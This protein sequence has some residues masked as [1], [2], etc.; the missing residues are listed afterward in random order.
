MGYNMS[1]T[2]VFTEGFLCST[3]PS[4]EGVTQ[5]KIDVDLTN[6]IFGENKLPNQPGDATIGTIGGSP[7]VTITSNGRSVSGSYE[8]FY[9]GPVNY[10]V[11][12][13]WITQ[14]GDGQVAIPLVS[15]PFGS[16]NNRYLMLACKVYNKNYW[17]AAGV[18]RIDYEF[19]LGWSDS[20]YPMESGST[21]TRISSLAAGTFDSS[22]YQRSAFGYASFMHVPD[23]NALIATADNPLADICLVLGYATYAGTG[24]YTH[25]RTLSWSTNSTGVLTISNASIYSLFY[26]ASSY[27]WPTWTDFSEEVGEPSKEGGNKGGTF[28]NSSDAIAIP[29]NPTIGVS[30]V[31]FINVYRTSANGLQGLGA[32]LF[33][34]LSYTPP[35]ALDPNA[36]T[37]E[38]LIQ[39]FDAFVT[40]LANVPSFFDQFMAG[41][42]INYIIDC[43]VIP[44]DPGAGTNESIKVG[45]KTVNISAGRI[46]TDYVDFSCGSIA[47]GEYYTNFADYTGTS[48]KIYLPFVGFVPC[49]PEWFQ[50]ATL[51][52]DYKFNVIDGSFACYVRAGGSHVGAGSSTIVGQY[53]GNACIH[54]PITGVTY[55]NMVSGLVGSAGGMVSGAGS[56]NIA[57]VATSAINAASVHGDIAQSNSYNG[58]AAFLGCRYPF[59]LIERPVSSY[60]KNYQHEVGIPANLYG[61]LGDVSGFVRMDNV[62]L[63]GI[64][65]TDEER[66]YIAE[67]LRKGVIV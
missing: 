42:Y 38:A 17:S 41:T 63:D 62:H 1:E 57:S 16:A 34:P 67:A 31:G 61:K 6:T 65:C 47:I 26:G 60:A 3:T 28:D 27:G 64:P 49:R 20:L 2:I 56:G 35:T 4:Y 7:L 19:Q 51:S 29:T 22:T 54:L 66:A 23:L 32:E 14:Y 18:W 39:G 8:T 10:E 59:L 50:N 46:Y 48:A 44:V 13:N 40:F 30:S 55:S 37:T 5:E 25:P 21:W 33:P 12:N 53:S 9:S 43:H 36:S 24:A 58:S 11:A 52:V 45:N 15:I